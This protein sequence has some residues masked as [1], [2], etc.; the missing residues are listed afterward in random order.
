MCN[1]NLKPL[2]ILTSGSVFLWG[3]ASNLGHINLPCKVIIM[4]LEIIK[5]YIWVLGLL[6]DHCVVYLE[7]W[8]QQKWL[9]AKQFKWI[10]KER[11][12]EKY[13]NKLWSDWFS[14]L[15]GKEFISETCI[16]PTTGADVYWAGLLPG[17]SIFF[18]FKFSLFLLGLC[19]LADCHGGLF[20]EVGD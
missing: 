3:G 19:G 2:S 16:L 20:A 7:A 6:I 13:F 1:I 5:P 9:I 14:L 15:L 12:Q 17:L 11:R 8:D 4:Y 10:W 18:L